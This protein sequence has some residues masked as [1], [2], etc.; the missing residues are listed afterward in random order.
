MTT[1]P[2][3][4]NWSWHALCLLVIFW[5]VSVGV[6]LISGFFQKEFFNPEVLIPFLTAGAL[7]SVVLSATTF[8]YEYYKS[9]HTLWWMLY[10]F[11]ALLISV[12]LIKVNWNQSLFFFL[13]LINIV[14]AGLTLKSQGSYLVGLISLIGYNFAILVSSQNKL[15]AYLTTIVV[16]NCSL[17]LV[18]Y[19]S[20]E[21]SEYFETLGIRLDLAQRDIRKMKNL[22]EL[23]LSHIPSGVLTVDT[24]G[25]LIQWN[26]RS[27]EILSPINLARQEHWE[28][29][30]QEIQ[31]QPRNEWGLTEF[32]LD[33][34]ATSKK[35]LRSQR[36]EVKFA[37]V[38]EKVEV[39][40]LDDVTRLREVEEH[41]RNQ[42]KLAAVGKLA[43]GIA[44]EI[45]NPLASISGSVQL[46]SHQ[47]G[48][49]EDKKL[50]NIVIKETDRLN[51]LITEFLD[52]AKP[53]PAPTDSVSL[54]PLINEVLE[55]VKLNQQLRTD[56]KV[57]CFWQGDHYILGFKDK[58]KQGLLNIII[59]AYQAL[60][61]TENPM[62]T[63][64]L[65]KERDL[66]VL[67]I[68]DNGSGMKEETRKRIF[69]PFF[70]TKSKGTG[71]GLAVTHKIFESHG[72]SII[73]ESKEG[74]GTEFVIKI[75]EDAKLL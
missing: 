30:Y 31:Y 57:Q 7:G 67:K 60:S 52:Y 72:A 42:E 55:L 17:L 9:T 37:D 39:F 43:A 48:T 18:S 53:F 20:G 24:Q 49:E 23:I 33:T 19:L 14:A 15:F 75:K 62:L 61:Q 35:T 5:C 26:A 66:V 63:V 32:T 25:R 54:I 73:V 2:E 45:R 46:L 36:A 29:L 58:L 50:F 34:G 40:V 1:T 59:N 47:A 71:L 22:H 27:Q 8:F 41:L 28:P 56:V 16:N 38:D 64:S 13:Y 65:E 3:E 6:V 68:K 51:M 12:I 4:Q 10:I 11:N 69:E 21:L 44:H 70:T 74:L